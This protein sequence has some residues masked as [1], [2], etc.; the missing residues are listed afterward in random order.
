MWLENAYQE[1]TSGYNLQALNIMIFSM[2]HGLPRNIVE[3]L[4]FVAD[5]FMWLFDGQ[6]TLSVSMSVNI[7]S[8]F[9]S[10]VWYTLGTMNLSALEHVFLKE[11]MKFYAHENKWFNKC[12]SWVGLKLRA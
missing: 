1:L 10:C 5:L 3:S 7:F 11:T 12:L 8:K 4:I 9:C 6:Q 2:I